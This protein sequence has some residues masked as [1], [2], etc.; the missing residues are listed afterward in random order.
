MAESSEGKEELP[1]LKLAR[2]AALSLQTNPFYILLFADQ[3]KCRKDNNLFAI[4]V[5]DQNLIKV[6]GKESFC[7]HCVLEGH[8]GM[9]TGLAFAVLDSNFLWSS[10]LDGTLKCWST[11]QGNQVVVLEICG[12]GSEPFTALDISFDGIFLSAGTHQINEQDAFLYTWNVE[13]FPHV[14][15]QSKHEDFHSDDI[16]KISFH[17]QRF[18][19]AATGSTDGLV[20]LCDLGATDDDDVLIQTFNTESSVNVVGFFG[21]KYE[22]IYS[23]THIETMQFWDCLSGDQ[24]GAFADIRNKEQMSYIVDYIIDCFYHQPSQRLF[25]V[26]GT[27]SGQIEV[28]HANLDHVTHFQSLIGCHSSTIRCVLFDSKT[29]RLLAGGE[30]GMISLWAPMQTLKALASNR[31]SKRLVKKTKEKRKPY[32]DKRDGK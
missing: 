1:N 7:S 18:S 27:F 14:V 28:L 26:A 9:I 32:K 21:P 4:A 24:L 12:D 5:S 8:K 23:L 11:V 2:A 6:Y 25:L 13:N 10:S 19:L 30:D 17:P 31:E 29:Q 15:L 16:T 22:Y 3:V 20:C